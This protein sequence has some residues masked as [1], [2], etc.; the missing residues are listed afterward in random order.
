MRRGTGHL[1]ARS[2]DLIEYYESVPGVQRAPEGLNPATWMLEVTMPGNEERLG[3]DFAEVYQQSSLNRS[4]RP[5]IRSSTNRAASLHW[6]MLRWRTNAKYAGCVLGLF[7]LWTFLCWFCGF[8]VASVHTLVAPCN[9]VVLVT[10]LYFLD[11]SSL[12]L[13]LVAALTAVSTMETTPNRFS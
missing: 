4:V 7:R 8:A 2:R 1:G 12:L 3:V 10:V 11:T 13:P 9:F 6:P 5:F